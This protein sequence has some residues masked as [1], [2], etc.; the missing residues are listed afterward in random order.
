MYRLNTI[1]ISL[2]G[3][4][5]LNHD[6]RG[7]SPSRLVWFNYSQ[8]VQVLGDNICRS[9]CDGL[10]CGLP[11]L[12][13]TCP[14]RLPPLDLLTHWGQCFFLIIKKSY[15]SSAGGNPYGIEILLVGDRVRHRLRRVFHGDT[16]PHRSSYGACP[17]PTYGTIWTHAPFAYAVDKYTLPRSCTITQPSPRSTHIST[18]QSP[19]VSG[20]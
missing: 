8:R 17:Q 12:W 10:A 13:N 4:I 3:L 20:A 5:L 1:S 18:S 11:A 7:T 15:L 19:V 14:S 6:I 9:G 16:G 2:R